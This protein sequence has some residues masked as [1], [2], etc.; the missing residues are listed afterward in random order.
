VNVY[1]NYIDTEGRVSDS[2]PIIQGYESGDVFH[3]NFSEQISNTEAILVYIKKKG[4]IFTLVK[5]SVN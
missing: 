3:R 4:N 5:V 2:K 1:C